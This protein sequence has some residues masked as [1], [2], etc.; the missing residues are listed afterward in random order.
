MPQ[1]ATLFKIWV[2]IFVQKLLFSCTK[3]FW[4]LGK[5]VVLVFA[6][7]YKR[8]RWHFEGWL[9]MSPSGKLHCMLIETFSDSSRHANW[10]RPI[11]HRCGHYCIVTRLNPLP[12]QGLYKKSYTCHVYCQPIGNR[13]IFS[14]ICP[15]LSLV[16]W[17]M[18]SP[19][20]HP[21]WNT[22]LN[23]GK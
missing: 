3:L 6:H 11:S 14:F 23:W 17:A 19:S 16:K 9:L 4:T 8:Y 21:H 22:T 18:F 7:F 10:F 5:K 2:A 20:F 12:R 1:I 15:Y 13:E